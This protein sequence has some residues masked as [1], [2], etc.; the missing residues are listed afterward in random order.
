MES[1]LTG[2]VEKTPEGAKETVVSI[3]VVKTKV[4]YGESYGLRWSNID[5]MC[6]RGNNLGPVG[7]YMED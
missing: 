2:W 4:W 6:C 1:L 7:G 3:F 5:R